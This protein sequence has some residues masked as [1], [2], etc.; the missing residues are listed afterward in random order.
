M[1]APDRSAPE[2]V[3]PRHK[4]TGKAHNP[5]KRR[6]SRGEAAVAPG[7]SS[8]ETASE[9]PR[10]ADFEA[11][12]EAEA[13]TPGEAALEEIEIEEEE[14]GAAIG[15]QLESPVS[16][17]FYS[18]EKSFTLE[19]CSAVTGSPNPKFLCFSIE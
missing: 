4:A 18:I 19:N 2:T 1:K 15:E 5:R 11:P 6:R 12:D 8:G 14:G 7:S 17:L 16:A 3:G 9:I 13:D 10:E